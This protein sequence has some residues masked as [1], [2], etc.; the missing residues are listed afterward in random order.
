MLVIIGAIIRAIRGRAVTDVVFGD[1]WTWPVPTLVL[2]NGE[3]YAAVVSSGFGSPRRV[4]TEREHSHAGLDI[5]FRRRNHADR[6]EYP[7]GRKLADGFSAGSAM[8]F[9]PPGT[10]VLAARPGNVWSVSERTDGGG[11]SVVIDH[12]KPWATY[13]THLQRVDVVKNQHVLAGQ[14]IGLMGGDKSEGQKL[15]HLHFEAWYQGAGSKSSVDAH[16]AGVMSD[17][18]RVD[19]EQS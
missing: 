9:A 11:W 8:H 5:M 14:V 10:P 2:P 13:Y 12:G 15:R 18:A 3:R 17:W 16:S 1:G 19:W 4:G 6:P 7:A